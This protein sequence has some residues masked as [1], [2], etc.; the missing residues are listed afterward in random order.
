MLFRSGNDRGGTPQVSVI[1][2]G[3]KLGAVTSFNA[4]ADSFTGGIR[5]GVASTGDL[6]PSIVTGTGPG[7]AAQVNL[8]DGRDYSRL[9]TLFSLADGLD[10]VRV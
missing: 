4:M 1:R 2:G 5:V 6:L 10:G 7:I 3:A 9:D 8:F